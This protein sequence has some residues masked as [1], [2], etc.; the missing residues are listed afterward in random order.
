VEL[1]SLNP[2][3]MQQYLQGVNWSA[4]KEQVARTA[5]SNDALQGMLD[6]LGNLGDGQFSGPMT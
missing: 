5:E 2:Q 1:G 6:Q 4:D 3:V